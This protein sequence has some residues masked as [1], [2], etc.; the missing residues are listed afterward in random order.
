MVLS[1]TFFHCS[2]AS[3][4]PQTV[5]MPQRLT[6]VWPIHGSI[7]SSGGSRGV[8]VIIVVVSKLVG[9]YGISIF[10][11]NL[12]PDPYYINNQFPFNNSV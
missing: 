1:K 4:L 10:V 3:T 9:F 8:I 2:L 12:M 6:S 11:G 7:C 5:V